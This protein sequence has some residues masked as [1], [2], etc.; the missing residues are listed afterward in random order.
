MHF[1]LFTNFVV[2]N[3]FLVKEKDGKL[4]YKIFIVNCSICA[5]VSNLTILTFLKAMEGEGGNWKVW[6]HHVMVKANK[7]NEKHN[8]KA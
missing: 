7:H 3:A 8:S 1:I 5:F 4:V 2:F 6:G